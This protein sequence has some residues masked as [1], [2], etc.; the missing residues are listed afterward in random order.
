MTFSEFGLQFEARAGDLGAGSPWDP[1]GITRSSQVGGPTGFSKRRI[2]LNAESASCGIKLLT[3][4]AYG[5]FTVYLDA[6]LSGFDPNVVAAAWLYDDHVGAV[7]HEVD[8]ESSAWGDTHN[9]YRDRIQVLIPGAQGP[10]VLSPP[11][12]S[13]PIPPAIYHKIELVQAKGYSSVKVWDWRS[14]DP[15]WIDRW[16]ERVSGYWSIES[17]PGATL[18]VGLWRLAPPRYPTSRRLPSKMWITNIVAE[19]L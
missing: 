3:P 16:I 18:R 4:E 2:G 12:P 6:P 15:R 7:V 14:E 5:R 9:P 10:V 17:N 8:W 11:V 1:A 13:V 19:A